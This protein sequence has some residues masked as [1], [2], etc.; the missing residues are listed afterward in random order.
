LA[1]TT[2]GVHVV[3]VISE[4]VAAWNAG[5]ATAR[6]AHLER[7]WSGGSCF[8]DPTTRRLGLDALLDYIGECRAGANDA[9]FVVL[10]IDAHHDHVR[11]TWA[12][13][14][15]RLGEVLGGHSIGQLDASGRLCSLVTF[16]GLRV[17]RPAHA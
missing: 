6:R 14:D 1:I 15:P 9:R 12:L 16:H 8:A 7:S 11:V 17:G 10:K 5:D 2:S 13:H 3:H 4:F